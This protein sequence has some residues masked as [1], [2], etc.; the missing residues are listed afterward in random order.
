MITRKSLSLKI[1]GVAG[2]F[3][4]V[5]GVF[6][7][8]PAVAEQYSIVTVD[9]SITPASSAV[10]REIAARNLVQEINEREGRTVISIDANAEDNSARIVIDP[11]Y[12]LGENGESFA[13]INKALEQYGFDKREAIA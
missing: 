4:M 6:G 11:E 7:V 10:L 5:S 2:S 12:S 1:A 13:S 3:M 8:A 9:E